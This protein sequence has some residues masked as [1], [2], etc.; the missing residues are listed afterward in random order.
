MGAL[1]RTQVQK[2][3]QDMCGPIPTDRIICNETV[4][5]VLED[6]V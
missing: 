2:I 5:G 4:N 6:H 1:V 3:V